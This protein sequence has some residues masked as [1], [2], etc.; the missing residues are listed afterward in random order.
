MDCSSTADASFESSLPLGLSVGTIGPSLIAAVLDEVKP[1][2]PAT[3]GRRELA[4]I[5]FE[6]GWSYL[7]T[8]K[9]CAMRRAANLE[10][11]PCLRELL[12]VVMMTLDAEQSLNESRLNIICR[13][14]MPGHGLAPHRDEPDMFEEDVYGCVLENTSG[15]VLEFTKKEEGK[16]FRINERPGTC[17]RQSGPAR[18]DWTHGIG[19]LEV[20]ERFSVTWRWIRV[21]SVWYKFDE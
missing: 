13:R 15:S 2:L 4:T 14:Y 21:D 17:V 7:E 8:T 20:G 9:R 16:I 11:F 10:D 12:D 5:M 19:K 6:V 3:D 1:H 18:F